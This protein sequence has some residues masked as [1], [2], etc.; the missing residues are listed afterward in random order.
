MVVND[1]LRASIDVSPR[2]ATFY[3]R[4]LDALDEAGIEYLLGGAFAFE[5]YTDIGGRTKDMDLFLHP[6]DAEDALKAMAGRGYDVELK[7]RHWLA[8]IKRGSDFVDVIFGSGNGLA[9]VDK[10]WFDHARPAEVLDREVRLI[11]VEE[12]LWS[13]SFIM[14]RERFDGADVLHLIRIAGRTMDWRR[15]I[16]R[17]HRFWPVL[18]AHLILYD[19]SYPSERARVPGWVRGELMDRARR[20]EPSKAELD[21]QLC[22]GTVLSRA[23]FLPDVEGWGYR[24]GRLEPFGR[25]TE[26]DIAAETARMREEMGKH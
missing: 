21:E 3:A 14:E 6:N 5:V 17:F 15:L 1:R 9:P 12:M 2:T 8:K 18:L 13:K 22:F 20:E 11:P 4:V 25:L 10:G 24:D 23:Q 26:A 16:D 7:A 19:F